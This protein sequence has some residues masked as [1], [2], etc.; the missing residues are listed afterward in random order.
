MLPLI[1]SETLR[2]NSLH[3]IEPN[4]FSSERWEYSLPACEEQIM[5]VMLHRKVQSVALI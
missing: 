3:Q 5:C 4:F 1:I 2:D